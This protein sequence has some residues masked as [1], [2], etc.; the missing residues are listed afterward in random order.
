MKTWKKNKRTRRRSKILQ[1]KICIIKLNF[2][3]DTLKRMKESAKLINMPNLSEF[4]RHVL[5]E[6]MKIDEKTLS[7][8]IPEGL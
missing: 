7:W 4:I 2:D 3:R 1:G 8:D 5:R 6:A